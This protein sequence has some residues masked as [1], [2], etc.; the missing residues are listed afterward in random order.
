[1]WNETRFTE[2]NDND[3]DKHKRARYKF[4]FD[5]IVVFIFLYFSVRCLFRLPP[6]FHSSVPKFLHKEKEVEVEVEE[7]KNANFQR[8]SGSVENSI[9]FCDSN[10]IQL[11]N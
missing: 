8:V 4:I 2:K 10:S 3:N 1:M 11:E 9:L 7:E 5:G 6:T